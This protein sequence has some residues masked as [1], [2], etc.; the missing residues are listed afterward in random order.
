LYVS[1]IFNKKRWHFKLCG[2]IRL[3]IIN[4]LCYELY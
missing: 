1:N 3:L 2:Y 4:I